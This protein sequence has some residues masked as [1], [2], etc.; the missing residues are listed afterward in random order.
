MTKK[1][2]GEYLVWMD[3]EMTGLVPSIDS[4]LEIATLITDIDLNIVGMG[5]ELVISHSDE[6]L[7]R[8]GEWCQAHHGQSGLIDK[9][10][11]SKL[12][13]Q[14]AEELTLRYIQKFVHK[15]EAPLC[16][17]SIHQDRN[18]LIKYMPKLNNYMHYRNVDVS[19]IK[20]L[21][22]RWYPNLPKFKK[23]GKH[24]ALEDIKES[25]GELIYY[26][27]RFFTDK[28]KK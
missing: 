6:T 4:I 27:S 2:N 18:F 5:P 28:I 16:G 7:Y 11:Q 19:T 24:T 1:N 25:I 26:R 23:Q 9:V 3:L 17:N 8:M 21:A 22:Y 20:E 15:G 10:K 13:M 12:T 14:E